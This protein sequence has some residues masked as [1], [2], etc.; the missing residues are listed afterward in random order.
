MNRDEL[1]DLVTI[2]DIHKI[3]EELGSTP[4]IPDRQG[5]YYFTTICHGGSNHKLL[6]YTKSKMFQCY[7]ACGSLSLFDVVAGALNTDFSEAF[8]FIA[9]FK[10]VRLG[11]RSVGLVKHKVENEDLDFLG[12]HLYKPKKQNVEL[13]PFNE[14]VLNIFEES[15][16]IDWWEEGINEQVAEFFDIRYYV[17]QN[18]AIIPHRDIHGNLVGI[19][20]RSYNDYEVNNGRKY[21]PV[22]VQGL[23]YR[24][25]MNFNLYGIYQNQH[26]IRKHKRVV[27]FE[28]E[29]AVMLYASMYGQEYNITVALSSMNMSL[30]QRDLLLS[31]GVEEV[32]F[33]LDKQYTL[34]CLDTKEGKEWR[35]YVGYIKKLI[36][37][38]GMFVNYCNVSVVLCYD[39]RIS[40]KDAPIDCGKETFEELMSE[41]YLIED[42][43]ELQDLIDE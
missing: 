3:M 19:R 38:T 11:K 10:G 28:S 27:V 22:T 15:Y 41:R 5:N 1:L 20:G 4:A 37:L 9:N 2:E 29:K 35:G 16:P 31:L 34:E 23:T 24:Y 32:V 17:S 26:N 43:E 42:V 12:L 6:Y 18:R 13:P 30:F 39:D 25:P 36:K 8:K 33:C 40:Y 14:H 21:M 7:T